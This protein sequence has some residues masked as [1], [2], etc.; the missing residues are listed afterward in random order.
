MRL[1]DGTNALTHNAS[2]IMNFA[3]F[4][5]LIC[6][7]LAVPAM[8]APREVVLLNADFD[9]ADLTGW[10]QSGDLCVAPAFCAGEPSGNYWIAM[11]TNSSQS[12]SITMCGSSS[13]DGLQSTLRSPDLPLPFKPSRIRVDFKIK[14]LTN[15]NTT[16]D[17]G[18]DL[19]TARLLTMAGP[20]V[21]MAVDD[22][23]ASPESK[24]LTV[25]GDTT[26]RDSD[27][28]ANWKSETGML[29]V[30]YY[31]SFRPDVLS[32]MAEGPIA[33]EFTLSNEFDQD[34]DSAV[35]LDDVQIRV[36]R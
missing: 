28:K 9:N 34:F 16:T 33:L 15:E 27:C 31:R 36:Y 8:A 20:V 17:L 23:G 6:M 19:F 1:L 26:F 5:M 2:S 10:R 24:N 29:Q 25:K 4:W 35:V 32:R 30:S 13:L 12:D 3:R 21:L 7:A 22:S 11:S 14:F 18:T